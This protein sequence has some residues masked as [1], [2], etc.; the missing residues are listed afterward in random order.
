MQGP[1]LGELQRIAAAT[2]AKVIAS[3]GVGNLTHLES[4][5]REMPANVEGVIVG[6]ALYEHAFTVSQAIGALRQRPSR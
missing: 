6:R 1:A 3:G 2:E 5:A 4:L